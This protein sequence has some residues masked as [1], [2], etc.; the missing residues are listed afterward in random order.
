MPRDGSGNYTQPF[1]DVV[2]GTTVESP[3]YNGFTHDVAID[4]NT[5]RPIV[6]GGTGATSGPAA[7]DALGGEISKVQVTNYNTHNFQAG[8]FYSDAGASGGPVTGHSFS[9]FCYPAVVL[10][11]ATTNMFIEARDLDD[12]SSPPV[13]YVRQKKA[14]VWGSWLVTPVGGSNPDFSGT[15]KL[16][17]FP[18]LTNNS[19]E[20]IILYPNATTMIKGA[21][22]ATNFYSN[23][24]KFC[25]ATLT[26]PY[27]TLDSVG[28]TFVC[29]V[30]TNVLTTIAPS[31]VDN[32]SRVPSTNWVRQNVTDTLA[33][34]TT[35][36]QNLQNSTNYT[37]V[38][39]DAGKQIY[40]TTGVFTLNIPN[41]ITTPFPIGS[42]IMLVNAGSG[43]MTII[44]AASDTLTFVGTTLT[45]ARTLSGG[46]TPGMATLVKV[47]AT[48]WIIWGF[49]LT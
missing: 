40:H 27:I 1:P 37:L 24:F 21:P 7:L 4:L 17:T 10:G 3:V 18:I 43:A 42:S 2:T 12:P 35:W 9:G 34:L 29:P 5:P 6:A 44:L 47:A 23:G 15:L 28:S 31:S 22:A 46:T 41:N 49:G 39:A 26:T 32:S 36:P 38:L 48:R 33:T 16:N 14:N 8:S 45:G 19:T 11:V 13:I 25:V 20:T 30:D